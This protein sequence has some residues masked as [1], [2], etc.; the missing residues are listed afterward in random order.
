LDI[1]TK[2]LVEPSVPRHEAIARHMAALI[3]AK[4]FRPGD[5][6]P[7][8]R[9]L[10]RT[11][12]ASPSTVF[13]A[14]EELARRGVLHA[15]PQSGFYVSVP[16]EP[17]TPAPAVSQPGLNAQTITTATL[18]RAIMATGFAPH[19]VSLDTAAPH[20]DLT[21]V[22]AVNRCLARATRRSG[23]EMANYLFP[24]GSARL[25]GE[26][27]RL[28]LR[29]GLSASPDDFVMTTGA[30]E[31]VQ[32]ALRA[33]TRP[34]DVVLTESPT[35]YGALQ[36]M[37]AL[38]LRV[39]EVPTH[40]ATGLV[41][42]KV[43]EA[44]RRHTVACCYAMPNFNNPLGSLMPDENK[45]ALVSVLARRGVP[46]VE[47]DVAG[48]LY[49]SDERPRAAKSFDQKGL[50]LLCSSVSKT[51]APGYRAG[52]I[53][54]GRFRERVLE[55]QWAT[56]VAPSSP[57]QLG[58]AEYLA[59]EAHGRHLRRLRAVLRANEGRMT[60]AVAESF[61]RGTAVSR[62]KGGLALWVELP[63]GTDAFKVYRAALAA[64]VA[65]MPGVIFSARQHFRRHLRLCYGVPW[66]PQVERAI[67]R[68]GEL[69][70]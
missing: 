51:L 44:L 39:L 70:H 67:H 41:L 43:E 37:E 52:W 12:K 17:L 32:L 2:Q 59:S 21:P 29:A 23:T 34:G 53:A 25:R 28:S 60:R 45:H 65:V 18:M 35:Y 31:A 61:P 20:A 64:G 40:P 63:P 36:A 66:T 5:R 3:S 4:T 58:M 57:A 13:E 26:V 10:A 50:V 38:G 62:P 33:V 54:P 56:T 14:Y 27:A 47:D 55:L 48:D 24:P 19:V 42:A 22:R 7:S 1:S 69:A 6:V 8:V 46:L 15:R 11:W 30:A 9:E 16:S 49:F 68:V